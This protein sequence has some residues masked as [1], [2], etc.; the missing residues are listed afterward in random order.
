MWGTER[1]EINDAVELIRAMDG[2]VSLSADSVTPM[3]NAVLDAVWAE[4][5]TGCRSDELRE[6]LGVVDTRDAGRHVAIARESFAKYQRQYFSGDLGECLSR[7]QFAGLI[8]DL[9]L[10]RDEL[11]VEVDAMIQRVEEANAEFEEHEDQYARPSA[12]RVERAVA[13]GA[14]R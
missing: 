11:G 10:F 4:A 9:E 6:L 3:R 14:G 2:A 13:Y 5:R 12:G 7:E 8:E 1:P